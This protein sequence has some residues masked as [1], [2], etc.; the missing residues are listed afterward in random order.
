VLAACADRSC[1]ELAKLSHLKLDKI[2]EEVQNARSRS[3]DKEAEKI[4]LW[5][6]QLVYRPR[7]LAILE[8]VQPGTG[9]WFLGHPTFNRWV[10]GEVDV[11]WCPGIR[12]FIILVTG[13]SYAD[14]HQSRSW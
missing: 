14:V 5:V 4:L 7:Q 10:H 11:L 1:R 13:Y 6:S 9:T 3:L 2:G 12:R 8:N